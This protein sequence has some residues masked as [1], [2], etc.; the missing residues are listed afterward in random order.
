[1]SDAIIF[2]MYPIR[3]ITGP[4]YTVEPRIMGLHSSGAF[5]VL[6]CISIP[7]RHEA[8]KLVEKFIADACHFLHIFH[9]PSLSGLIH[10]LYDALDEGEDADIGIAVL[11][12]GICAST[13]YTW[14]PYDDDFGCYANA[15]EA[16][17]QSIG[18]LKSALDVID[19]AQRTACISLEL[20][21]GMIVTFFVLCSLEGG[22]VRARSLIARSIFV[23]RELGL[24]CIDEPAK[25]TAS[26][27]KPMTGIKAE[28]GRRIW[29]HLAAANW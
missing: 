20:M 29:W 25:P 16:N 22:S 3:L 10:G 18:W 7:Q 24:H 13:A 2:R 21:Q 17:S 23:G 9:T 5:D 6:K 28:I 8:A 1:M 11:L 4:S 14:T 12:L 19:Y 15:A 27:F 26:E